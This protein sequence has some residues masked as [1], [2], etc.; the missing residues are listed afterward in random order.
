VD[1]IE[2]TFEVLPAREVRVGKHSIPKLSFVVP[3]N[4]VGNGPQPREDGLLPT[5]AFQRVFIASTDHY[6]ALEAW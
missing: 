2:Q 4:S 3:T 6:V 1:G 5:A